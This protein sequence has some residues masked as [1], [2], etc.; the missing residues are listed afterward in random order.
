MNCI[1][2]KWDRRKKKREI[3][4]EKKEGEGGET[5]RRLDNETAEQPYV[6]GQT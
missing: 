1:K 6:W 3:S 4:G 2:S 5:G